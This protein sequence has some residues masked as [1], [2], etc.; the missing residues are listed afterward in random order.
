MQWKKARMSVSE[1]TRCASEGSSFSSVDC[2]CIAQKWGSVRTGQVLYEAKSAPLL[3]EAWGTTWRKMVLFEEGCQCM[4]LQEP[5]CCTATPSRAK[6]GLA[7]CCLNGS[8]VAKGGWVWRTTLPGGHHQV[9]WLET[10]V[11]QQQPTSPLSHLVVPS[12]TVEYKVSLKNVNS[13]WLI[14]KEWLVPE[15][16]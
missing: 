11:K 7:F 16:G 6:M 3:H 4:V 12:L 8:S 2:W 10:S 13:I 9:P 14:W 15:A 5:H 1:Q